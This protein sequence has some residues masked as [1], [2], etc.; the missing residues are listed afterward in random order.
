MDG[1]SR[2]FSAFVSF[3]KGIQISW[4]STK[5]SFVW[6]LSLKAAACYQGHFPD[7]SQLNGGLGQLTTL[8]CCYNFP[9]PCLWVTLQVELT[10]SVNA[11]CS[12]ALFCMLMNSVIICV[13][14]PWQGLAQDRQLTASIIYL[15]FFLWGH[16][17]SCSA[18]CSNTRG[19]VRHLHDHASKKQCTLLVVI[20]WLVGHDKSGRG[21]R[22]AINRN[23]VL[24]PKTRHQNNNFKCGV[25]QCL[26]GCMNIKWWRKTKQN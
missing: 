7:T 20:T 14:F 25:W 9:Q 5:H 17:Q 12:L 16:V 19:L 10:L 1:G 11:P 23:N 21:H 6:R 26:C 15:F 4:L 3:W 13:E 18:I 24:W 2:C 8:M 22:V